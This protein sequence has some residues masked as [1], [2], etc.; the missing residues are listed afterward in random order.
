MSTR[1]GHYSA[2]TTVL[3]ASSAPKGFEGTNMRTRFVWLTLFLAF[4]GLVLAAYDKRIAELRVQVKNDTKLT[5][6]DRA[7]L[8]KTFEEYI[9]ERDK[10]FAELLVILGKSG[11][12]KQTDAFRNR[13]DQLGKD[14][15]RRNSDMLRL[16][17]PAYNVYQEFLFNESFFIER[18]RKVS[19]PEHRDTIAKLGKD[20][21]V[22]TAGLELEWQTLL[23]KDQNYDDQQ[24]AIAR[25]LR[26]TLESVIRQVAESRKETLEYVTSVATKIPT[27]AAGTVFKKGATYLVEKMQ[28]VQNRIRQYQALLSYEENGIYVVYGNTYGSTKEFIEKNSFSAAKAVYEKARDEL[29]LMYESGTPSQRDDAKEFAELAL[30][31]L[32]DRLAETE[33]TFNQFV[34][35]NRGRFFGPLSPEIE[36]ALVETRVWEREADD[37]KR[38]DLEGKLREWRNELNKSFLNIDWSKISEGQREAIKIEVKRNLETLLD[39]TSEVD[40]TFKNESWIVNYDRKE[41]AKRLASRAK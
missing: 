20:L 6:P 39:A 32:S 34:T 21:E 18:L 9:L 36:E 10:G 19:L 11:I 37:M 1:F 38:L 13:V 33:T 7:T 14:L 4:T 40:P 23:F 22:Y 28:Y 8:I 2:S 12:D 17:L 35:K 31:V 16:P 27:P 26:E 5:E 30:K 3:G 15:G 25:D 41:L 29:R 24:K